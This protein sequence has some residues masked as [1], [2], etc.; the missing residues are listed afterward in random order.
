MKTLYEMIKDL[1]GIDVEQNKINKYLENERLDLCGAN[2]RC[3]YLQ[4]AELEGA[5]LMGANLQG[6]DLMGAYLQ[7]AELEGANLRFANLKDIKL[8]QQQL[9]TINCYWGG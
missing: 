3:A 7:G 6:A 4:G 1:T 9:G 2:L 5:D 8:T